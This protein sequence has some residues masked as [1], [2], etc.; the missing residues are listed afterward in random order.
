MLATFQSPGVSSKLNELV[1]VPANSLVS[2][3]TS[4]AHLDICLAV[5]LK[6]AQPF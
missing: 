6:T 3:P 2:L 1:Y 5:V 4:F